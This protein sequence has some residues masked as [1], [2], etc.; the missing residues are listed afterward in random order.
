MTATSRWS[1]VMATAMLLALSACAS[2][3]K[4][5]YSWEEFPAIQYQLLLEDVADP[6]AQIDALHAQTEKARAESLPLPPGFR[7]HLAMLELA[8]GDAADARRLLL[9]E[10]AVFPE[11]SIYMD[12][13]LNRLASP[14]P[15]AG[16]G[17]ENSAD[18]DAQ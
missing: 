14:A 16:D 2:Q 9:E 13:L 18:G 5:M 12:Q 4:P 6:A 15:A 7:A 3:P 8:A 1:R 11:S 17:S 10:K